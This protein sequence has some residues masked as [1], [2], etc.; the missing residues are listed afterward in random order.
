[1]YIYIYIVCNNIYIY[2]YIQQYTTTQSNITYNIDK[3]THLS[4]SIYIYVYIYVCVCIYIYIYICI[5]ISIS[6]PL[7]LYVYIYIYTHTYA[8]MSSRGSRDARLPPTPSL[9]KPGPFETMCLPKC[10]GQGC[11]RWGVLVA[12]VLSIAVNGLAAT[13]AVGGRS[14]AQVSNEH[15]KQTRKSTNKEIHKET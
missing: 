11:A 6:I 15:P 1:M 8:H 9:R 7:S 14:I 13:G 2:T 5:Y 3:P 4:L 12:Y 10:D